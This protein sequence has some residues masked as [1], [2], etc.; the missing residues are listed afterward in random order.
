VI[1]L[2]PQITPG[3]NGFGNMMSRRRVFRLLALL[4]LV[5]LAAVVEV[6]SR[7][8]RRASLVPPAASRDVSAKLDAASSPIDFRALP[9]DEAL[10]RVSSAS[11][12]S[13]EADWP[14]IEAAGLPRTAPVTL[15][16]VRGVPWRWV[17]NYL[18]AAPGGFPKYG[19][20]FRAGPKS[21]IV[22]AAAA[23]PEYCVVR[24]YPVGDILPK[25][26]AQL[27]SDF[28]GV[29]PFGAEK[30]LLTHE[31]QPWARW[32]SCYLVSDRFVVV[33]PRASQDVILER[34]TA[35]RAEYAKSPPPSEPPP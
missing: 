30:G 29:P 12:M 24:E 3:H 26:R 19:L 32:D 34:L 25:L 22:W 1:A 5:A 33:A 11:G 7:M 31:L 14:A 16:N 17:V 27:A 4:A 28:A 20:D 8:A 15:Y 13:I 10:R 6:R 18:L 23:P 2:D 9:L 21:L 35:L